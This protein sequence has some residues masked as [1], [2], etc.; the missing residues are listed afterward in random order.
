[1][2]REEY[3]S[4]HIRPMADRIRRGKVPSDLGQTFI[5]W[6]NKAWR[7]GSLREDAEVIKAAF[8]GLFTMSRKMAAHNPAHLAE[9]PE[10]A[11]LTIEGAA[12]Q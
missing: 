5:D 3:L 6:T 9:Y 1:M 10:L 12:R 4:E 7:F 8:P 11:T 2:T